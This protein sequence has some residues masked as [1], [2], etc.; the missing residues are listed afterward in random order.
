[1]KK[2]IILKYKVV[3]DENNSAH[4]SKVYKFIFEEI[5]AVIN[6]EQKNERKIQNCTTLV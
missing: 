2:Q 6:L 3:E 4:L 5:L 1:M